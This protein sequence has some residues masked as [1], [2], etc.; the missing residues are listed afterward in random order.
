MKKVTIKDVALKAKVG[1]GTVSRVLNN[2]NQI[3]DKLEEIINSVQDAAYEYRQF[4]KDLN[5]LLY[6]DDEQGDE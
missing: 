1:V 3:I 2:S 4:N 6:I 5:E